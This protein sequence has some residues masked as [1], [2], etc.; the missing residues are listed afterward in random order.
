MA[1]GRNLALPEPLEGEDAKS[2]F[3]CHEVCGTANGWNDQK[4]FCICQHS[5]K[6]VCNGKSPMHMIV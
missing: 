3:K 2:C 5:L 1:A 6:V 4:N